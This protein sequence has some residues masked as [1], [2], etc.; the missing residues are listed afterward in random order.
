[1]PKPALLRRY[2]TGSDMKVFIENY[3]YQ[4]QV[5]GDV[6]FKELEG[7]LESLIQEDLS[8][9]FAAGITL[10]DGYFR[11]RLGDGQRAVLFHP[12]AQMPA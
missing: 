7:V 8:A 9:A 4:K 1:M 10:V 3:P 12:K 2:Q 11:V 5:E 6:S